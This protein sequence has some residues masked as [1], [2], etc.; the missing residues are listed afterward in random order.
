MKTWLKHGRQHFIDELVRRNGLGDLSEP[1]LC[2]CC[3]KS[4]ATIRCMEC[5]GSRLMCDEC[6]IESHR[7]NPLHRIEVCVAIYLST[8]QFTETM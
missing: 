4:P 3:E 2:Y 7:R 8:S 6:T 1:G 5:S